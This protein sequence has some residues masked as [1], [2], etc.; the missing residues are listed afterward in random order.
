[1][2]PLQRWLHCHPTNPQ[3]LTRDFGSCRSAESHRTFALKQR[4]RQC[5]FVPSQ[6]PS[7]DPASSPGSSHTNPGHGM[8]GFWI[9]THGFFCD[10]WVYP[11][12]FPLNCPKCWIYLGKIRQH[13]LIIHSANPRIII[14]V[15]RSIRLSGDDLPLEM[16]GQHR[17]WAVSF[18]AMIILSRSYPVSSVGAR[19]SPRIISH[20]SGITMTTLVRWFTLAILCLWNMVTFHSCVISYQRVQ[21]PI[22]IVNV[23]A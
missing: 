6:Y 9:K 20:G 1:M 17:T 23:L 18:W 5:C 3:E 14:G 22:L 8:A 16:E 15:V 10:G 13:S 21:H 4:S 11:H 7:L 2:Q 19:R 12:L